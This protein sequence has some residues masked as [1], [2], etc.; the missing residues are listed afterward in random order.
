MMS[1]TG[2]MPPK[3]LR[4][5]VDAVVQRAVRREQK[6]IGAAQPLDV[7]AAEAAALHADDVEAVRAGPGRP[8]PGRRESRRARR[9]TCRRSSRAGRSARTGAPRESP[10]STAYS[11]TTTCPASVAL[12]AMMTWSP[13]W[14]SCAT[15]DADHEQAIVADARHHAAAFGAGVHRHVFADRV[16]AADHQR[17]RLA[18]VFE[19]LRLDA[20]S[21]RTGRFACP[22]RSCVRP[23]MTT[24]ARSL[25]P[26]PSVTCS[27]TTQ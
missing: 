6:L 17:R 18:L 11:P 20:R 19:V 12:L 16:V 27:P 4:G 8:S 1:S 15:C 26:A 21:R 5:L 14:Q 3:P 24:C 2:P 9:P 10:P 7:L 22:R 23:S 25:T 13:I